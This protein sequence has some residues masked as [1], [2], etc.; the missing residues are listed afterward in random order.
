[1]A[2]D[3]YT[4]TTTDY[5]TPAKMN[6]IE[7]G[8]YNAEANYVDLT[9]TTDANG[10]AS[11]GSTNGAVDKVISAMVISPRRCTCELW[12]NEVGDT[13]YRIFVGARGETRTAQ[14][15]TECIIRV[16]KKN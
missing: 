10:Y 14:A 5:V 4:W 6:N 12:L 9:V 3:K 2:Y 15:S 7:E 8:V 1:M 13:Y 16:W 11:L